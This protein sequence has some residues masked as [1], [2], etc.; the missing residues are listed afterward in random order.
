VA[1]DKLSRRAK[2]KRTRR[3]I[4]LLVILLLSVLLYVWMGGLGSDYVKA[5]VKGLLNPVPA[6][7][8]LLVEHN[9]E[10]K[11]LTSGETLQAQPSDSLKLLKINTSIPFNRH[12]R[13]FCQGLDVYAFRDEIVIAKLLPS[14]EPFH[15]YNFVIEIK[16]KNN[17]LGQ[18]ALAVAPSVDDWLMQADKIID[19]QKR[20]SFLNK[21]VQETGASLQIKMRLADEY[22]AL[23]SWR[24]AARIIEDVLKEKKY[25]SLMIRLADAYENLRQYNSLIKTLQQILAETPDNLE[26][27]L[28]LAEVLEKKGRLNEAVKQYEMLLPNL[29]Q[30]ERIAALK[31]MGYL[32]YQSGQKNE[33][34]K[35]YLEAAKHDKNDPNLYYNIGSIYDELKRPKEAE[36]YLRLAVN[37]KQDDVEGR[38]RLGQSLFKKGEFAEAKRYLDEVLRKEPGNLEALTLLAHIAEKQDDKKTLKEVYERILAREP[39]NTTIL[40]N[41]G[42]MEAEKGD[43]QKAL[44]YFEKLVEIDPQDLQAR[45]SLFNIYQRQKKKELAFMQAEQLVKLKPKKVSYYEY[46]FNYLL[47]QSRFDQAAQYMRAGVE[48][49]PENLELRKNLVLAYLKLGKNDL[50]A[51]ELEQAV[52]L[53]PS[54]TDLLHQLATLK[55]SAGDLEGAFD[56]YKK[57]LAISPDDEKAEEAYLKLRFELLNKRK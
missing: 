19:P 14:E 10:R 16:Y 54:D 12:I 2:R 37:L 40:F 49:N 52:K 5:T 48:A 46:L 21:A 41:L 39:K 25:V 26:V 50:A 32:S 7:G 24:E 45:E 44:S 20:I 30:A 38:L 29:S 28:R 8:Y 17:T 43:L 51:K 4:A 22:T 3:I 6:F 13:L 1:G 15:Q 27:R 55:E 18:V 11:V 33:A 56:S 57:I 35:W 9:G 47:D 31:N 36:E 42:V 53:R 34:L 23:K